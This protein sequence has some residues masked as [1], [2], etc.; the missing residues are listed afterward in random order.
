MK[1]LAFMILGLGRK[2]RKRRPF[3]LDPDHP[4]LGSGRLLVLREEKG[5]MI[6][7][8]DFLV[9]GKMVGFA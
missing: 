4:G 6:S 3:Q 1:R 7:R 9:T 2:S 8:P 5:G